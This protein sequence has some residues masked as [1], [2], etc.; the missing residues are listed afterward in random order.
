MGVVVF[1]P[2]TVRVPK[3]SHRKWY[4]YMCNK[5]RTKEDDGMSKN[6]FDKIIGY[7]AIKKELEQIADILKNGEIYQKLGVS[8]PKGLLLHGEPGVG[9]TLMANC[10][11]R[12]SE[13]THYV[14][15]KDRPQR[16]FV[17]HIKEAFAKAKEQAPSIVF[18]DDMDKFANGD[19]RRKDA[20]EYVTVQ[21]CID[22][23]KD[24]DVFV[25][26]T[27]N[28]LDALPSS[29][30]RAG[31]LGRMIRV[32]TPVGEDAVRIIEHYLK[33]KHF[34]A[35]L[36]SSFIARVLNDR[37]CAE[38]ETV[39][40]E[41]GIYAGFSRSAVIT[42]EHFMKACM[43]IIFDVP[44]G[45]LD[46]NDD[47]H[48]D[49]HNKDNEISQVIYHE[50]GHA[51]VSEVL[52]PESV[53]IVSVHNQHGRN[54]GFTAYYRDPKERLFQWRKS[55]IFASLGGLAAVEQK[56]GVMEIGNTH[57]FRSAF[58]R[59]RTMLTDD[60]LCGFSL[61]RHAIGNSDDL[62][63]RQEQVTAAEMEKYYRKTKEI[64]A[65]NADFLEQVAA[66]LAKKKLLTTA[67][68]QRIKSQCTITAISI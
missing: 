2:V 17:L 22:E 56:F 57:D 36:D 31:R 67:D 40:N 51:V 46:N 41:A 28:N 4:E 62:L 16:E 43:H 19:E 8:A 47:Y 24:S 61:Y 20:E 64:L 29:L 50:A 55:R 30:L 34:V 44:T 25:L 33:D 18:L 11:I 3:K 49:L 45:L 54:G 32:A 60:C 52:S 13:R 53:T 38:L 9:K 59:V 42:M 26:A 12:A 58:S 14:C 68:I 10:L 66:E 23:V 39:I 63:S 7:T 35:N 37:S 27:A 6:A 65:Q 1:L 48:A 15:R 5:R 21:S